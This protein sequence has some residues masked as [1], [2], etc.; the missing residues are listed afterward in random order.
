MIHRV[1]STN[2]RKKR[3]SFYSSRNRGGRVIYRKRGIKR[4]ER[5]KR[6]RKKRMLEG[7]R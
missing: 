5:E 3:R 7:K 2:V 6:I 1:S 4:R